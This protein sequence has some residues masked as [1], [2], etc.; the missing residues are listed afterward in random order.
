MNLAAHVGTQ[1]VA[2]VLAGDVV[3]VLGGLLHGGQRGTLLAGW[4]T[5]AP[6]RTDKER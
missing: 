3:A 6:T 2:D 5:A 1:G 4:G